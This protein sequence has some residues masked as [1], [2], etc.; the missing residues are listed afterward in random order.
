M[1][2]HFLYSLTVLFVI[3][4]GCLVS[5][6]KNGENKEENKV[7]SVTGIMLDES[8]ITLEHIG[9]T[10][11]L[12]STVIPDNATN[13]KVDWNSSDKTVAE[14]EEDG[15]VTAKGEGTCIITVVTDDGG[16]MATCDI[17]VKIVNLP[18]HFIRAQGSKFMLYDEEIVFR[19]IGMGFTSQSFN[20]PNAP[21]IFVEKDFAKMANIGFN[22]IRLYFSSSWFENLSTSP[23][24]Y[25]NAAWTWLDMRIAWA[26]KY[27]MTLV[28]AMMIQPGTTGESDRKE[29]FKNINYQDR[30]YA[31]W[32]AIADHCK[33]EPTVAAYELVNEPFVEL[34][35]GEGPPFALTFKLYQTVIQRTVDAIREVDMNHTIIF[36]RMWLTGASEPAL[37]YY[38]SNPNDQ[39]D[40][41]Q[42]INGKYNFPDIDDP[43]NNYALSYHCY[44]PGNYCHQTV[45]T[46]TDGSFNRDHVYPCST[47]FA[48]WGIRD[49]DG[50]TIPMQE[51]LT[52]SAT[53][54]VTLTCTF[55]CLT[56]TVQN[57][58]RIDLVFEDL[59]EE[60]TVWCR[61]VAVKEL[62]ENKNY[63]RTAILHDFTRMYHFSAY[64]NALDGMVY[65]QL[66]QLIKVTGPF[67]GLIRSN[68]AQFLMTKGRYYELSMEVKGENIGAGIVYP[69]LFIN[70]RPDAWG[71]T[72][73][74]LEYIYTLPVDY[75][76]N[77]VGVPV[78]IGELGIHQDNFL[79]NWYS[80]NRGGAQWFEDVY[81]ILFD[82]R[83]SS[84][85]HP[86]FIHEVNPNFDV[87][88]EAAFKKAFKT[89]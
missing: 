49:Q 25:R 50:T 70:N 21:E 6:C 2:N 58:G 14:V 24:S 59:P 62:D 43:A 35:G 12:F 3:S 53:D 79:D 9:D 40:R 88:L 45:Y 4:T 8:A 86:Y 69:R 37:G 34:V 77:T 66:A 17:T 60:A 20:S 81:D 31:L 63:I 42:N 5:T 67:H 78:Y 56:T 11:Q 80:I 7:I 27:N 87:N 51:S 72:K 76:K 55:Q 1:K 36:E 41:W 32:K 13:I 57:T 71:Y 68:G 83:L 85:F 73:E 18:N 10:K 26:K 65:D 75:I 19:G 29:L 30:F 22:S 74:F 84:N 28:L 89:N 82:Y 39:N 47:D 52:S 23:V 38:N 64:G 44:E 61:K 16:F 48:K 54:Y 46:P 33:D 15:W